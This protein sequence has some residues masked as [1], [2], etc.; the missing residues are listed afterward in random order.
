LVR[1]KTS[2]LRPGLFNQLVARMS[3]LLGTQLS[4]RAVKGRASHS[5]L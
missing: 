3:D 4:W 2:I 1:G 5:E